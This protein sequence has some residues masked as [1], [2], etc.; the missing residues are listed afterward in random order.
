MRGGVGGGKGTVRGGN[1]TGVGE[2]AERTEG[3]RKRIERL[4]EE[5]AEIIYRKRG[6]K[7]RVKGRGYMGEKGRGKREE[8]GV[9]GE[10]R[11]KIERTRGEEGKRK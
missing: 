10:K 4:R 9:K 6:R 5:E 2:E 11:E 8:R 3:W 7:R 1:R